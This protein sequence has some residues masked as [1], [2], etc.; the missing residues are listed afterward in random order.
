LV[1]K[2]LDDM[3]KSI[4]FHIANKNNSVIIL[5][6]SYHLHKF[7]YVH[8]MLSIVDEGGKEIPTGHIYGFLKMLCFIKSK[9]DNPAIIIAVDGYDRERKME[10]SQYKSNRVKKEV[11]VHDSVSDIL[12]MS[13]L[14]SGVYV[15]YNG[16][17]EADDTIYNVSRTLDTLFKKNKIDRN[18]YIYSQDKDLMQCINDKIFMIRK[19]GSGKDW[20]K[21][22]DIVDEAIVREQFKGV[23]P[24]KLAMFRSIAG[25]D[26]ADN[27]K[28]YYRFPKDKA[29]IIVEECIIGDNSIIVPNLESLNE[30][31]PKINDYISIINND[32]EKFRSNYNIMK[33]KEYDFTLKIP[34]KGNAIELV[35]YYKLSS[36]KRELG[37]E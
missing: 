34:N 22:A 35:N 31:Y 15:S 8:R 25:G 6:M 36:Y 10:N 17:Y 13:S 18:I 4:I 2:N 26:S 27:I 9:F 24:E 11:N 5:D 14:L 1:K 7:A 21:K 30:K 28:G 12:K 3:T 19:F 16:D 20:F 33:M 32:F 23:G 29:S 37:Y